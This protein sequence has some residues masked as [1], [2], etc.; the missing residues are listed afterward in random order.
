VVIGYG[1]KNTVHS[2]LVASWEKFGLAFPHEKI[3][4]MK[5]YGIINCI[6]ALEI[7]PSCASIVFQ[8]ISPEG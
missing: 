2:G 5:V 7:S 1:N 8:L 3:L 4:N 6:F